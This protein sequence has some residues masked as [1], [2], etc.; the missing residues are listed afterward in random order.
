MPRK[1]SAKVV[2]PAKAGVQKSLLFLDSGSRRNDQ[3]GVSS[4]FLRHHQSSLAAFC[5]AAASFP[6]ISVWLKA[7]P[8]GFKAGE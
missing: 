3:K 6:M 8:L 2:T 4:G 5:A 1:K 7:W